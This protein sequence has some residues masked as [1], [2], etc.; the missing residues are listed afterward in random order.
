MNKYWKRLL[1]RFDRSFSS[2]RAWKP[3]LWVVGMCVCPTLVFW[4]FGTLWEMPPY[5]D[6]GHTGGACIDEVIRLMIGGSNYPIDSRM[7]HWYQLLIVFFG[8]MFFTAFLISTLSNVLANRAASH[9]K[10]Y[11]HYYFSN[12]ILILGGS[13][14][15]LGLLKT[16]AADEV[17]RKKDVVV[18]SNED[19]EEL[20]DHIVPLLTEEERKLTLTIYHGERNMEKTLRSCQAE[21]ASVIY[22]IGEDD[23]REH[24]SI[25]V[26]CW[27]LLKALRE[28]QSQ[29]LAQCF[30]ALER[31]ASSYLFNFLSEEKDSSNVETTI[32]NHLESVSQQL[33]IG[34]DGQWKGCTLDRGEV[35]LGSKRYVHFV[36]VG[37]S[38]MGF[39]MASTAAQLCHYPNFD[40][41]ADDPIRTRITFIDENADSEMGLFKGRY[42]GLF[43]LSHSVYR[44]EHEGRVV[45]VLNEPREGY[46]DF[47][48]V[49]WEFLKG[50]VVDDWVRRELMQWKDDE[51]QILTVA[52]CGDI[53][54]RNLAQALYLPGGFFRGVDEAH[55][56]SD[57]DPMVWVY[58]P[59]NSAMVETAREVGRYQNLFA[60]GAKMGSFDKKLAQ[61]V[62]AAKRINYLYQKKNR[63]EVYQSM[64][65]NASELDDMWRALSYAEKMSNIYAANSIHAKFRSMGMDYRDYVGRKIPDDVVELMSKME[66]ARWNMEKLL[67]GFGA[68]PSEKRVRINERMA[69]GDCAAKEESSELKRLEFKHKDIAPYCELPV[70]SKQYDRAIVSNLV[71]VLDDGKDE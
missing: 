63:N 29:G 33:L 4:I 44:Y 35:V 67:V 17:L 42:A 26:D 16:I 13:K 7:P 37:M 20:W 60:F 49:E 61:R 43:E 51:S 34:D 40:E 55:P 28:K 9:R 24:D 45:S 50:S 68:L 39:A 71:D 12:H 58:Q 23:E 21:L 27:K 54:E 65:G 36:I 2:N 47:L 14:M 62:E 57:R 70:Q 18:L 19:A 69:A 25:N 38:Q 22:I 41:G 8:T 66:H 30:L 1:W 32:V 10:G 5:V 59:E 56:M 52:F 3:L 48:D 46:G 6:G 31:N 15:V 53:P 11:L 64:P